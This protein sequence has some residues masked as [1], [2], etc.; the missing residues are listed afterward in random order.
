[1]DYNI[2]LLILLPHSSHFTQPLDIAIFGPL[3][4]YLSTEV[5]ELVGADVARLIKA[6]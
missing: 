6:E 4:R 2:K 3:K 1:M 5:R